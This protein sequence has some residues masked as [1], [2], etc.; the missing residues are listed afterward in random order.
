MR[1]FIAYTVVLVVLLLTASSARGADLPKQSIAGAEH[2]IPAGEM[3]D[4]SLSPLE[5][6][7]PDL[8]AISV[9]WKV[10]ELPSGQ[11]RRVRVISDAGPL[12]PGG[13]FFGAG[14]KQATLKVFAAVTYVYAKRTG[15]AITEVSAQTAILTADVRVS[16]LDPVPDP[17][18]PGPDPKP[19]PLPP[20]AKA[21]VVVVEETTEAAN[22]RGKYFQSPDLHQFFRSKQ[23]SYRVADKDVQGIGGSPPRDLKPW[24]DR[25][26]GKKLPWM[27]VIDAQGVEYFSGPVPNT[28]QGL[29]AELKRIGGEK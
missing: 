22:N 23:W 21:W 16:G 27:F 10:L 2:P 5:K 3:V 19:D 25:A 26:S 7:P 29:L 13:I 12:K 4:L 11:E 6:L 20:I 28:P 1:R 9:A 14:I 15:D 18:P 17:K 24:L 8:V